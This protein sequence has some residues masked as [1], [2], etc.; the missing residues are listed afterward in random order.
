MV[1]SRRGRGS[2]QDR[3]G[4]GHSPRRSRARGYALS[5]RIF[6]FP[7]YFWCGRIVQYFHGFL[8]YHWIRRQDTRTTSRNIGGDRSSLAYKSFDSAN[9]VFSSDKKIPSQGEEIRRSRSG[10]YDPS[11]KFKGGRGLS[12][13]VEILEGKKYWVANFMTPISKSIILDFEAKGF[14]DIYLLSPLELSGFISGG[15]AFP[16]HAGPLQIWNGKLNLIYQPGEVFY[17]VIENKNE[18]AIPI[19]FRVFNTK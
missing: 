16:S 1:E 14:V 15:R 8:D 4:G 19:F 17:L 2:I 12:M 7:I 9:D 18:V 11:Y 13:A 3:R 10:D 5:D 6:H